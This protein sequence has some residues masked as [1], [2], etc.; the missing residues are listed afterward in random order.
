M[1]RLIRSVLFSGLILAPGAA[2]LRA[3]NPIITDVLTADPAAMVHDGTVYLYTSHDEAPDK[4]SRYVM[5]NWL[6]FSSTDMANWIRSIHVTT[7][8]VGAAK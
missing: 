8:G 6:C 1:H 5:K 7:E 3:T 2:S 4:T